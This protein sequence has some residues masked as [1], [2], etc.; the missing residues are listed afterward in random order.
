MSLLACKVNNDNCCYDTDVPKEVVKI[1]KQAT[2]NYNR[3]HSSIFNYSSHSCVPHLLN[4]SH[5][6]VDQVHQIKP[7]S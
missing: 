5:N 2:M 7:F 3:A 4:I 1:A 6:F